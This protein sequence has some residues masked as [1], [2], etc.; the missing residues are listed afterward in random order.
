MTHVSAGAPLRALLLAALALTI[1]TV[2][3]AATK[4]CLHREWDMGID[5]A[6]DAEAEVQ[7]RC[8]QTQDFHRAFAAFANKQVP[9]FE[10]N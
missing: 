6:I 5:D 1:T 10:G 4:A 2:A 9:V 3:H 8:M 7:A